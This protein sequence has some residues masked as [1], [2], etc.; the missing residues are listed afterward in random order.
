MVEPV[1]HTDA[2]TTILPAVPSCHKAKWRVV[3]GRMWV[4]GWVGVG[5]REGGGGGA[6]LFIF[7]SESNIQRVPKATR[8]S[9]MGSARAFRGLEPVHKQRNNFF[10]EESTIPPTG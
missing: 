5:V 6:H 1:G 9:Y 7:I 4:G 10:T 8:C 2:R 3:K